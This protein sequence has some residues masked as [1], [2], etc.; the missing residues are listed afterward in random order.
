MIQE[1][2]DAEEKLEKERIAYLDRVLPEEERKC[3]KCGKLFL[4]R[5]FILCPDCLNL[6]IQRNNT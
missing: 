3:T 1:Q 5:V 6:L 4:T 2:K